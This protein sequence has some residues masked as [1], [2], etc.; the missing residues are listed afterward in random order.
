[1]KRKKLK[2]FVVFNL[3]F[4]N[5]WRLLIL[6]YSNFQVMTLEN[7]LILITKWE[8]LQSNEFLIKFLCIVIWS[9]SLMR[10]VEI[11]FFIFHL[12]PYFREIVIKHL[13]MWIFTL[14]RI[15]SFKQ[16]GMNSFPN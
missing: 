13:N 7:Y 2:S 9:C 4:W 12:F 11:T 8:T 6:V 1:M 10:E 3:A 16:I 15:N 14:L 5:V